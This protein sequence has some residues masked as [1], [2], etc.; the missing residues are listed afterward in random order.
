MK[1]TGIALTGD[2]DWGFVDK[3]YLQSS[4]LEGTHCCLVLF[5]H[6]FVAHLYLHEYG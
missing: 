3:R 2:A 6:V 4:E 1:G 5:I